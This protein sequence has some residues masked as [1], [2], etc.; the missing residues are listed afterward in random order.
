MSIQKVGMIVITLLNLTFG[1]RGME[2][3][4]MSDADSSSALIPKNDVLAHEKLKIEKFKEEVRGFYAAVR[5]GD[6]KKVKGYI[7]NVPK[8]PQYAALSRLFEEESESLVEIAFTSALE[9]RQGFRQRCEILKDLVAIDCFCQQNREYQ[10]E[11]AS[12]LSRS[13]FWWKWKDPAPI[14][15]LHRAV[16]KDNLALVVFLL[17][18]QI[19][20]I[21]V[22]DYYGRNALYFVLSEKMLKVLIW[23]GMSEASFRSPCIPKAIKMTLKEIVKFDDPNCCSCC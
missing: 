3:V 16:D 1:I 5:S 21:D 17:D 19:S 10:K 22:V 7:A 23:R 9:K 8:F 2:D 20:D 6:S 12:E 4:K 15:F 11:P 13:G 18:S 14:Y